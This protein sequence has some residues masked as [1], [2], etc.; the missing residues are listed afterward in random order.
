[1]SSHTMDHEYGRA[2]ARAAGEL[3]YMQFF[4]RVFNKTIIPLALVGYEIV[5]IVKGFKLGEWSLLF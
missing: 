3:E 5:N 1:M 4:S 2:R